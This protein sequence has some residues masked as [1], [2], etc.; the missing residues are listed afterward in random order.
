MTT[1]NVLITFTDLNGNTMDWFSSGRFSAKGPHKTSA[2]TIAS[3][4]SFLVK[5]LI[6]R[7]TKFLEIIFKGKPKY[8]YMLLKNLKSAKLLIIK[9]I[10]D[11]TSVPHS[12]CRLSKKRRK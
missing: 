3:L 12:G 9:T 8:R 1:N 5:R 2:G 6:W 11:K 10:V 4:C 7:K